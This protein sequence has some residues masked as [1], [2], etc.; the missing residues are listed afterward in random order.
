MAKCIKRIRDLFEYAPYKLHF[1]YLGPTYLL[2]CIES[3]GGVGV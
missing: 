1:T 2:A 3:R